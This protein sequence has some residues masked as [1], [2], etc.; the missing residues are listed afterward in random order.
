MKPSGRQLTELTSL[1]E[2][3]KLRPVIDRTFSLAEIQAAFKYSQSHRAKG[4]II[5]KIDDSVA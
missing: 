2:Q 3:T 5:I 1:I 4:K